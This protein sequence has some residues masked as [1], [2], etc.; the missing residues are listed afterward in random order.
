LIEEVCDSHD[1]GKKKK[2]NSKQ[3]EVT[4]EALPSESMN[5]TKVTDPIE[6][7]MLSFL[8]AIS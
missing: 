8:P 1:G 6:F 3:K 5:Y 7:N 2:G 4:K